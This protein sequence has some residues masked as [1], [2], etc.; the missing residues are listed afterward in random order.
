MTPLGWTF[1][2]VTWTALTL[3]TVWCFWLILSPDAKANEAHLPP[4]GRM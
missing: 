4:S 2:S 3:L 1:L